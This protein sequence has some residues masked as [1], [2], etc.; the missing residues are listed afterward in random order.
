LW[1][2]HEEN[3]RQMEERECTSRTELWI[4]EILGDEGQLP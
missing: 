3:K 2:T 1:N 4:W